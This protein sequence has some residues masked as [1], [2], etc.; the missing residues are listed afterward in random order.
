METSPQEDEGGGGDFIG[1]LGTSNFHLFL[2]ID[3]SLIFS[4]SHCSCTIFVLFL[5][6]LYTQ[7]ILILILINVQFLQN[8]VSSFEK[9]SRGQNHSLS[10]SH[11]PTEK[12]PGANFPS[13][14]S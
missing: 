11:H 12:S 9:G 7:V 6:S 14:Y 10:D 8:V 3:L 5:Y 13:R 2:R 4:C 1:L